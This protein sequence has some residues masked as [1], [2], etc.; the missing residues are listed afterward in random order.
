MPCAPQELWNWHARPGAFQRLAPPWVRMRLL[1]M[2]GGIAPGA[3]V[4]MEVRR[5][6][7]A[8]RWDAR[9][10]EHPLYNP[11]HS[12][13]DIQKSGPFALWEH[14]HTM[15]PGNTRAT[16]TLEDHIRFRLPG[17]PI[18]NA[19]GKRAIAADLTR[20]FAFRHART[21][22]DL[23]RHGAFSAKVGRPLKAAIT[24]ASG[25][26]GAP[27][28]AMLTT[29]GHGVLK[30][31]RRKPEAPDE[32]FWSPGAGPKGGQID[33]AALDGCDAVIHLAGEPLATGR[34]TPAKM[35]AIRDSRVEG[36]RLIANAVAAMQRPPRVLIVA[37]GVHYYGERGDQELPEDA[38]VGS[39]YIAEVARDWEAAAEPARQAGVRV[40]TLRIGLVLSPTGGVLRA[41]LPTFSLGLGAVPGSGKQWW[42]W[43][44][45][46]ELLSV[47]LHTIADEGLHG[48]VNAVTPMPVTAAG[49]AATLAHCLDRPLFARAP[50]WALRTVLGAKVE[51]VLLSTRAVP[52]RLRTR[53]YRFTNSTLEEA[54]RWEMG[55]V[56]PASTGTDI[57]IEA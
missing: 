21:R 53:G 55:L 56:T 14:T 34:W 13:Y 24:G 22:Y 51:G 49:F 54:L 47:I 52:E 29:G 11:P 48:A 36:T 18:G 7:I 20:M 27:L 42:P 40:V 37:S 2:E 17:G 31:V 45:L 32:V 19:L 1:A 35:Q 9:H 6:P 10:P 57:R 23:A 33:E 50:E 44:G 30:L 39:G 38:S 28:C 8:L 26:I 41:L 16:S 15:L 12:F 25:M 3:R 5:G 46:D 4:L 43:I